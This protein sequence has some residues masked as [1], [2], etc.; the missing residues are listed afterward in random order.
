MILYCCWGK[1]RELAQRIGLR[2]KSHQGHYGSLLVV[3][4]LSSPAS[5]AGFGGMVLLAYVLPARLGA[6]PSKEYP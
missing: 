1:E 4:V 2:V 6:Y 3:M 5:L